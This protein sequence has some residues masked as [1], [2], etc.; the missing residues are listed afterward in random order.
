LELISESAKFCGVTSC[1]RVAGELIGEIRRISGLRQAELARR[2][3]MQSSV[4]SAYVHGRR[5]PSVAALARI[6][7]AAG[8]ELQLQVTWNHASLERAGEILAQVLDLADRR[9]RSSP[10]ELEY[11]PLIRLAKLQS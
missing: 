6:A 8:L 4:I 7:D 9:P 2:A 3:G 11:P 5:Q 10:K 1:D